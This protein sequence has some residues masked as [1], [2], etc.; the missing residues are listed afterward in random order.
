MLCPK[1]DDYFRRFS[2][3]MS[4]PH[5]PGAPPS[6]TDA[7][8]AQATTQRYYEAQCSKDETM[9]ES[10]VRMLPA[11]GRTGSIVLHV[12]GAFHSDYGLGTVSRVVRRAPGVRRLL[13]TAVPVEE[14]A[15]ATLGDHGRRADYV[16]FTRTPP[17]KPG[18]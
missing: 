13:V 3:T 10:I 9:A 1:D 16:I 17:K 14:P 5:V 11:V 15:T 6:A 8:A 12:N 2:E 4:G 7:A 18:G